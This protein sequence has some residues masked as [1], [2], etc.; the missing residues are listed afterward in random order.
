MNILEQLLQFLHTD[1][2]A[3]SRGMV[4]G[5]N[6]DSSRAIARGAPAATKKVQTTAPSPAPPEDRVRERISTLADRMSERLS[7]S[8]RSALKPEDIQQAKQRSDK[9]RSDGDSRRLTKKKAEEQIADRVIH[10]H[11]QESVVVTPPGLTFGSEG[12]AHE[13]R[14]PS[15]WS[16]DSH[17]SDQ[18]DEASSEG[19]IDSDDEAR[20]LL[21]KADSGPRNFEKEDLDEEKEQERIA[22]EAS[23]SDDQVKRAREVM[24]TPA[25]G[26]AVRVARV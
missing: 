9:D 2:K 6:A 25:G 4:C 19:T 16:S 1:A 3:D 13:V 23:P 12:T 18:E 24:G 15:A 17:Y 7:S 20:E 5:H 10:P 22:E 21:A 26:R 11:Q 8:G 14:R